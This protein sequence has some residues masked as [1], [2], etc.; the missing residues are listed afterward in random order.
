MSSWICVPLQRAE[1]GFMTAGRI[2]P[3]LAGW[4]SERSGRR[5]TQMLEFVLLETSGILKI[6][7]RRL[8]LPP[9]LD[10]ILQ[11]HYKKLDAGLNMQ[12]DL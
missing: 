11:S 2:H 1:T 10:W 6:N 4:R 8:Q 7:Q 9:V 3:V 5:R 12:T